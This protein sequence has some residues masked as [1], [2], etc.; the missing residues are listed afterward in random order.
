[1]GEEKGGGEIDHL[2]YQGKSSHG[3][4]T[5]LR[6]NKEQKAGDYQGRALLPWVSCPKVKV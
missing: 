1:M 3:A 5:T 2:L 6:I 4:W